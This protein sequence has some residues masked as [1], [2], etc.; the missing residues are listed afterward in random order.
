MS[1]TFSLLTEDRFWITI[2]FSMFIEFLWDSCVDGRRWLQG[3]MMISSVGSSNDLL[4]HTLRVLGPSCDRN[5]IPLYWPKGV[6]FVVIVNFVLSFQRSTTPLTDEEFEDITYF[7]GSLDDYTS[8]PRQVI[9]IQY[10]E[11]AS[12][13]WKFP[14]MFGKLI[15]QARLRQLSFKFL[16]W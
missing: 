14:K 4:A 1:E 16:P 7:P 11:G 12:E 13:L 5:T 9:V 8:V 2:T 10:A 3:P 6:P 15:S